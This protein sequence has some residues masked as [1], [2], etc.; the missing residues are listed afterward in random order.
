VTRNAL[1]FGPAASSK[2]LGLILGKVLTCYDRRAALGSRT[3]DLRI[4][5]ANYFADHGC[6]QGFLCTRVPV[7]W[8]HEAGSDYRSR[9]DMRHG[10]G[11]E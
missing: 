2:W 10:R 4:T 9:H 3:P 1:A 6:Y 8:L 5:S 7:N 11:P